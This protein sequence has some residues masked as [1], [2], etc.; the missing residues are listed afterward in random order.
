MAGIILWFELLG[1][2]DIHVTNKNIEK[3]FTQPRVYK[4]FD[5]IYI[6]IYI[7][8]NLFLTS[9]GTYHELNRLNH[10]LYMSQT[11]KKKYSPF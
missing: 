3:Y 2:R 6:Y 1:S 11:S 9:A 5:D 4:H 7:Y 10:V 8:I